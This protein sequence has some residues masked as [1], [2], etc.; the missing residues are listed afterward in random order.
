MNNKPYTLRLLDL[1]K[2]SQIFLVESDDLD[3]VK[4]Q[5][6]WFKDYQVEIVDHDYI[7]EII[8][9]VNGDDTS[10]ERIGVK[11]DCYNECLKKFV[12][13]R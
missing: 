1:D 7:I 9:T 8:K 4:S 6:E 11:K 10:L 5:F 13:S 2:N 12:Y 3:D